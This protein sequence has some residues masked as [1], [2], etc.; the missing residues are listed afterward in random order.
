VRLLYHGETPIQKHIKVKGVKSPYDGDW[1]YWAIRLG[2]HPTL[3]K[4]KATLLK[5]QKGRCA[6]CGLFFKS[7]DLLEID[8]ILPRPHGRRDK[9]ANQQLLHRHCHDAKTARDYS[10]A[11]TGAHYKSQGIEEPD[12]R[13]RS[14]PVLK[15]SSGSDPT[16]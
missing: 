15:P 8:H 4:N 9:Y 13:K 7:D 6:Y 11:E 16:A 14:R 2:K 3:P 10:L 1:M 5:R 12:E